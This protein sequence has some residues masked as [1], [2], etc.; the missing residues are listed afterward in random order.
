MDSIIHRIGIA[1]NAVF[2]VPLLASAWTLIHQI[3]TGR[4]SLILVGL[5]M[6]GIGVLYLGN[7]WIERSR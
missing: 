7:R 1:F 5:T 6:L 2:I 4:V 3:I